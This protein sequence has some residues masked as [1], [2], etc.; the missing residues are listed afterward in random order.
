[1]NS[2]KTL[3]INNFSFFPAFPPPS[4]SYLC[5]VLKNKGI[6]SYQFDINLETW[7]YFLSPDY[8][9]EREFKPDNYI[10]NNCLWISKINKRQFLDLKKHTVMNITKAINI[11]KNKKDFYDFMKFNWAMSVIYQAQLLIYYDYGTLLT[12]HFVLWPE[13]GFEMKSISKIYLL[14]ENRLKN[15]FI[16]AFEKVIIPKI[17]EINPNIILL[18]IVWPQDIIPALTLNI[19]LKNNFPKVHLNYPGQGFDEFSFSRLQN[20]LESQKELLFGFD[21]VFLY[22]NDEGVCALIENNNNKESLNDIANL[23]Y[24]SKDGKVSINKPF[25]KKG[26][27]EGTLNDYSDLELSKYYIP[28]LVLIERLT[29]KC[30]WAKCNFCSINN[31]KN[32]GQKFDLDIL[33]KNFEILNKKYNC[34]HFWLLD[35][36][37]PPNI[38]IEFSKKLNE[39]KLNYI[40]SLRTRVDKGFTKEVLKQLYDSG[41]REL[42]I[43]LEQVDANVLKLMNKTDDPENYA[44]IASKILED[45]NN[46]GIGIHFCIL[47]GMPS[48]TNEQ[49]QK[50]VDFFIKNEKHLSVMP[51]FATFNTFGL[52][53][54]S[55]IYNNSEQF[56]V[57]IVDEDV[58]NFNMENLAYKTKWGDETRSEESKKNIDIYF[59]KLVN[60]FVKDEIK[61]LSWFNICDSPY[62]ILFKEY[63]SKTKKGNPFQNK[64]SNFEKILMKIYL[65]LSNFPYI[66]VVWKEFCQKYFVGIK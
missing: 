49:R 52:M 44:N 38:A 13:L 50:V 27:I 66:S 8:L 60:I 4:T 10:N 64:V 51:F 28:E 3:V 25:I 7:N 33:I 29:Y 65:Y 48:E 59:D 58:D 57:T 46:I 47:L 56:G 55:Y 1:M 54:D 42:W 9:K 12:N 34:R 40:W 22:R 36:G 53:Y 37:C 11:L 18:D 23:A 17:K 15:P 32:D 2:M 30:F 43:G 21:S 16:D 62:E 41:L 14:S 63:Y 31:H 5:G 20:K 26:W 35:E 19:I 6:S 45:C 39:K 24:L 61:I